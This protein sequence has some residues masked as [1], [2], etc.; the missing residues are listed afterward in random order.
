[1]S[2]PTVTLENGSKMPLVGFG[3]WKVDNATCQETVY[4]AIKTGYRL[5][6]GAADYGN[7]RE[8]G[9]G[10][11]QAI[12]EGLVKREELFVTTKLWNT[13]HA[14]E[15][16]T[17]AFERS[18]NDMGLDYVDLYLIH[19]PI[20]IAYVDPATR[21]PPG[22]F[23]DGKSELKLENS[24]MHETWAGMEEVFASGRAKNIG[25]SNFNGQLIMDLLRYAKVHP[26]VLQIEHHP[27]YVQ[28]QLL[29]FCKENKIA[30]T[31]YSS[32]GPTSY[33]ELNQKLAHGTP[34]LLDRPLVKEIAE[35]HG[36]TNSQ[37][38][39]R[40]A[41]QRGVAVIP[42]S[43]NQGRLEQNLDV[44]SFDLE[45]KDLDQLTGLDKHL[46]FNS[47][48]LYGIPILATFA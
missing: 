18:L 10:I 39:L 45:Q 19:F 4:N 29:D 8:V 43:N 41:T 27:Y 13:N 40:W 17:E 9:A 15:H 31:A 24:P 28:Q 48:E 36:K 26:A 2:T 33:L 34:T 23:Y 42:K 30:V 35:K 20:A 38:L 12:D 46:K 1:M 37:V 16:V 11:R 47:P 22:F 6:D 14:K 21:Y 3:C 25:I 32:F 5:F 7:E 44:C